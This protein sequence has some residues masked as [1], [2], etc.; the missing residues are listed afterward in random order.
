MDTPVNFI[1][2]K[3]EETLRDI[4]GYLAADFGAAV[5]DHYDSDSKYLYIK[6]TGNCADCPMNIMTLQ[7]GIMPLIIKNCS[8]WVDRVEIAI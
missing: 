2:Q 4:S 7:A 5:Y 6:F 3:A 1:R 8:P